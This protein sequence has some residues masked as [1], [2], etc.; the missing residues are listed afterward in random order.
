MKKIILL[1]LAICTIGISVRAAVGDTTWVQAN[2]TNLEWYNNYDTAVVFPATGATYRKVYMIFT[3]GKHMCPG[4]SYA[5]G[6]YGNPPCPPGDIPWCGDWDYTIL[7][8]L[9]T[10]AGDTLEMARLISPYANAGAPRTPYTWTQNYVYDVTDYANL[11]KGPATMRLLY[12][13]YS[14]GFTANVKFAFIEGTPDRN[15]IKIHRL[16]TGSYRYGDTTHLDS[17][18]INTHFTAIADTVPAGTA[19]TDLRFL[20]TGHGGD[21]TN[22][23]EFTSHNYQV[24]LDSS[25]VATKT[26]WR[27]D[28]GLNELYPQSGTWLLQRGNW[29]P[30]ALVY[31]NYHLLP[32]LT[33]GAGFNVAVQFDPF[34]STVGIYTTEGQ[35][36]YYGP[37]NKTL[38]AS[39]DDIIT[40][41]NDQNH[42]RENPTSNNPIVHVKNTGSTTINSILFRYG[43]AGYAVQTY[44]WTGTMTSLQESDISLPL[45]SALDSLAGASGTYSFTCTILEVND[46]PDDDGSNNSMTSSFVAAPVWPSPFKITLRTNNEGANENR[47]V[48]TDMN[49]NVVRQRMGAANSSTYKDTVNLPRGCYKLQLFDSSCDG[50][51]WWAFADYVPVV[52]DGY[53]T[54]GPMVGSPFTLHGNPTGSYNN[55]YGCGFVQYFFLDSMAGVAGI[56]NVNADKTSIDAYPNPAQGVVNID[57][58][59]LQNVQGSIQLLDMAGRVVSSVKCY[60]AHTQINISEF[61]NGLYMIVYTNN[62]TGS[63]AQAKLLIAK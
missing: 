32:G 26:I 17:F 53:I 3:L 34:V 44:S 51:A 20:V 46:N 27:D 63:R 8:Y 47:W 25:S 48:I 52:T 6:N 36:I 5:C 29:C 7:N 1:A 15:V 13:G 30:G 23:C 55:D 59:G 40:P 60:D 9:M 43:V 57:I 35:L 41:T 22:C 45:L 10:P 62:A 2:I 14:G 56:S 61:V 31:P 54:V 21:Q 42:F 19:T 49:N 11:M 58:S 18:D 16:W 33:P 37:M 50:L 38:D 28:C 12:S 24:M 4:Y 39:L